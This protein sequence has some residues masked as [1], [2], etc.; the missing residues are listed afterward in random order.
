MSDLKQHMG[1]N[2]EF[3]HYIYEHMVMQF[4]DCQI[5]KSVWEDVLEK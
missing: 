4:S 1:G 3:Y 5:A 2:H